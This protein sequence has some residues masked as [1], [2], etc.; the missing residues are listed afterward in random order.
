VTAACSV[1]QRARGSRI[2]TS[3]APPRRLSNGVHAA[4]SL[5]GEEALDL[6]DDGVSVVDPRK[7]ACPGKSNEAKV[8]IG[9]DESLTLLREEGRR[10]PPVFGSALASP[11][12]LR[13][14]RLLVLAPYAM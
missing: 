3:N 12:E 11:A 9:R 2:G 1:F 5:S 14:H 13:N 4:P 8:R 7:V 6:D 10:G